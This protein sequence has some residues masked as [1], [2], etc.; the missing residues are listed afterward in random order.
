MI[1]W[2]H[3]S[4]LGFSMKEQFFTPAFKLAL[5]IALIVLVLSF[6]DNSLWTTSP[7]IIEHK[8][9][10]RWL[11]A[12]FVHFGWAHSLVN[13]SGLLF[14]TWA[15]FYSVSALRFASLFIFCALAVGIGMS[16]S[17]E[18]LYYAGLSGVL[19]GLVIAGSFYMKDHALWK[20]GV[21][22]AITLFK[23][24]HEQ[25][26]GYQ[27]NELASLLPVVV[28]IDAHLIGVIA[29]FIFIILDKILSLTIPKKETQ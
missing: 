16:L 29:A 19:H 26:A 18:I 10:W 14:F 13:I 15:S 2:P 27:F 1:N 21:L 9:Y 4:P 20:R 6:F 8:E 3:Y 11:T 12:N 7:G 25:L 24:A 23:V 22:L 5:L 28:A 17:N